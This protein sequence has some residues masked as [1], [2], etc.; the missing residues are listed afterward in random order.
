MLSQT[1]AY[2]YHCISK[3]IFPWNFLLKE[4]SV[5][6]FSYWNDDSEKFKEFRKN[7]FDTARNK[8]GTSARIVYEK[9]NKMEG[10]QR[11]I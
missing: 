4:N 3:Y 6:R 5:I 7:G 2:K 10:F 8:K 9:T 11:L 1:S